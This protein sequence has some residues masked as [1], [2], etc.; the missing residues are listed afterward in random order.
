MPVN[1]AYK[2]RFQFMYGELYVGGF[3]N[4]TIKVK[5]IDVNTYLSLK[6]LLTSLESIRVRL[7]DASHLIEFVIHGV[8]Y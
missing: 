7:M 2:P 5:D 1:V 3:Q 6:L 4:A 8:K